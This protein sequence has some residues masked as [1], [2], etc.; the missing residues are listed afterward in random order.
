MYLICVKG[1]E[2]ESSPLGT[3]TNPGGSVTV[4]QVAKEK[5]SIVHRKPQ[6]CLRGMTFCVEGTTK[7]TKMRH[8]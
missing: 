8:F 7:C 6:E 4:R 5:I 3:P 2:S 1:V